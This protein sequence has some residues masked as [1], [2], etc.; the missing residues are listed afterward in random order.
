MKASTGSRRAAGRSWPRFSRTALAG[1]LTAAM[2]VGLAGTAQAV[3]PAGL[4]GFYDQTGLTGARP[5]ATRLSFFVSDQ[6]SATV[7]VGANS[8]SED[9]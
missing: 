1:V 6:V 7:D 9:S 4:P 5:S 3:L 2:V 8:R